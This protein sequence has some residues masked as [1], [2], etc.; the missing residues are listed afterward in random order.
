MQQFLT[1]LKHSFGNFQNW[2]AASFDHAIVS[3]EA[4]FLRIAEK[5]RLDKKDIWDAAKITLRI[6]RNNT[7]VYAIIFGLTI[8]SLATGTFSEPGF[9]YGPWRPVVIGLAALLAA[10]IPY[11][12]LLALVPIHLIFSIS[13]WA[14]VAV[15]V[16]LS[17]IIFSIIEPAIPNYFYTGGILYFDDLFWK[18]FV[19]YALALPFVHARTHQVMCFRKHKSRQQSPTIQKYLPID[20]IGPLIAVSAQDHYVKITTEKGSHLVRLS[21]TDA[22]KLV[23]ENSGVRVH[24][25]HWVANNTMLSLENNSGRY[26]VTLQNGT[27]IPV[28]KAQVGQVQRVLDSRG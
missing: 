13:I 18:I 7:D 4:V 10:A 1:S 19:F 17:S 15:N 20:K 8:I 23:P 21:M 5:E 22:T 6:H 3:L 14:L 24:R 25:S 9:D 12:L 27:Q 16:V 26:F 2:Q 11:V 28:A